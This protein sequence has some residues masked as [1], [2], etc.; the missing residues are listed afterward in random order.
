M[1]GSGWTSRQIR[2][3]AASQGRGCECGRRRILV[4]W[5]RT[6][7]PAL[8]LFARQTL[9]EFDAAEDAVQERLSDSGVIAPRQTT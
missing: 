6:H 3:P 8:L 1:L 4:A 7:G 5:F 2:R 9:P